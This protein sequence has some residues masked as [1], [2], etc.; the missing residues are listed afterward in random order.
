MTYRLTVFVIICRTQKKSTLSEKAI[1]VSGRWWLV[2][3]S[4]VLV[5][6][7]SIAKWMFIQKQIASI[8][9]T[10]FQ[11]YDWMTTHSHWNLILKFM[12]EILTLLIE[13]NVK[14]G[15]IGLILSAMSQ[16]RTSLFYQ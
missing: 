13:I 5:V 8:V 1:S 4:E 12:W 2:S 16:M 10:P 15:R 3:T 9:D 7:D 14:P 11:K 6:Y